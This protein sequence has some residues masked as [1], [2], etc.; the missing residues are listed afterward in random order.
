M[1]KR[2]EEKIILVT[3]ASGGLGRAL[4]VA[5][6]KEGANIIAQAKHEEGLVT[7]QEEVEAAGGRVLCVPF[8]LMKFDD[9]SK[10]FLGL[11]DHI[12]HL[13]GIAHLAGELDRCAPMQFIEPKKFR[14]AIDITLTAPNLLTQMLFPMLKRSE[15]ASVV[16]TTC[17][18][19]HEAQPNWHGYGM[20]KAALANAAAMW[21][22]EHPGKPIRFNA[23]NPG[24]MRTELMKRAFPGLVPETIPLP[25]T[26][27][28][29]FLHLLSDDSKEIR[30]QS[31][32]A[33]DLLEKTIN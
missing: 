30:G 23:L 21:Q 3:G 5:L 4:C 28:P 11:K 33:A 14:R 12:P 31:L 29:T 1:S 2:F 6:A 20:A 22:L 7:V 18:M 10:L 24:R 32:N 9:Y 25:E 27:V 26:V 17:D 16:F 13:D 8:D 15:S 19:T